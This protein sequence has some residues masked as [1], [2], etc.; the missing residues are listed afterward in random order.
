MINIETHPL[1][2]PHNLLSEFFYKF[3][4]TNW[5]QHR[6]IPIAP[7]VSNKFK[8]FHNERSLRTNKIFNKSNSAQG[9]TTHSF[10][11]KLLVSTC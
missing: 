5:C 9:V 2:K 7:T 11:F 8:I 4:K 3:K 1:K 6:N 10:G